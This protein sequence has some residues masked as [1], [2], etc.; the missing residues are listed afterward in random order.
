VFQYLDL[1][2]N[3]HQEPADEAVTGEVDQ[4]ARCHACQLMS[5]R[6]VE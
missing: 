3:V 2:A 5:V 4:G 1:A 6:E